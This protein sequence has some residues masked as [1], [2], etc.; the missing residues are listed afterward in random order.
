MGGSTVSAH[1][2]QLNATRAAQGKEPVHVEVVAVEKASPKL[3]LAHLWNVFVELR[4]AAGG[5]GFG[6]VPV[7]FQDIET[8]GRLHGIDFEPW[9]VNVLHTL[10]VKYI[11]SWAAAQKNKVRE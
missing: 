7:S 1:I 6:P 10:D 9:E 3:A 11:Q 8:Y 2:K 4:N 5:S